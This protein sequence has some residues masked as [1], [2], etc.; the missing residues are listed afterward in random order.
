[1]TLE[2]GEGSEPEPRFADHRIDEAA[3]AL[4]ERLATYEK[5]VQADDE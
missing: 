1:M 5:E 4:G 2:T 3:R